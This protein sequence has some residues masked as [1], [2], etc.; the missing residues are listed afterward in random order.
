[1]A[2]LRTRQHQADQVRL[3]GLMLAEFNRLWPNL[4]LGGLPL[5]G[6]AVAALLRPYASASAS[7]AAEF[8]DGQRLAAGARTRFTVPVADAPPLEQVEASMGWATRSLRSADPADLDSP[9][10]LQLASGAAQKMV[11][12][13]GRRTLAQAV[14]E[15]SAA[16]GWARVPT[17]ATTCH[18]CAMLCTRGAVYKSQGTAGRNTNDR[19][20]GEG[21]FKFHSNDDCAVEPI[22][23]GQTYE[24]SLQIQRWEQLYV[25][26]TSDVYGAEKR[27]AFRRAFEAA[28]P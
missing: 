9:A 15:D 19:F 1:M 20:V 8:Y 17:G 4:L 12:D 2:S 21:S 11:L 18:F 25:D 14:T 7:L 24:P 3:V 10:V 16:V 27:R 26:S 5:L 28:R 6:S 13:T 23:V 22:F